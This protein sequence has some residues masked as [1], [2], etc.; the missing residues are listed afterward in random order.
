ML[1]CS[2]RVLFFA[3]FLPAS[4]FSFDNFIDSISLANLP[5]LDGIASLVRAWLGVP[6]VPRFG[7][8]HSTGD[9][10]DILL[11]PAAF[12]AEDCARITALFEDV[13][14]AEDTRQIPSL[15]R[16]EDHSVSRISRFDGNRALLQR[17]ALDFVFEKIL[18]WNAA[19]KLLSVAVPDAKAFRDHVHLVL[20]HEFDEDHD[21]SGWHA[22]TKPGDPA[23]R[24]WNVNVMLSS[25]EDYEGGTLQVGGTALRANRG[26]LYAYPAAAPHMVHRYVSSNRVRT[27]FF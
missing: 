8:V 7:G 16:M 9:A 21:H 24:S 27:D 11:R 3:L 17:G 1:C 5:P 2:P 4:G 23:P 20:L 22:E 6:S 18:E 14:R 10:P 13:E 26:D 19:G 15:P 12:S 25:P